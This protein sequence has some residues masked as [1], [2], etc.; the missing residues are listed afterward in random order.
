MD[1]GICFDDNPDSYDGALPPVDYDVTAAVTH[2]ANSE[3]YRVPYGWCGF[4]G[5]YT[6]SD[7]WHGA[8]PDCRWR[9][10]HYPQTT[11]APL[12]RFRAGMTFAC[13]PRACEGTNCPKN[14][15]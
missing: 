14:G 10:G 11:P 7:L 9:W 13:S 3:A 1:Y 5:A 12:Q 8:C 2:G 15:A 4:C 6:Y